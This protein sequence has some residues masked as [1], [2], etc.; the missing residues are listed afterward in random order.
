MLDFEHLK[1]RNAFDQVTLADGRNARL[2]G[3]YANV[4]ANSAP[5]R[6]DAPRLDQ[7]GD[8]IRQEIRHQSRTRT[9]VVPTTTGSDRPFHGL[10][11][12]D[13]TWVIAGPVS[14]RYLADHG[15]TVIKV[16]SEL[17]PDGLRR[18]GPLSDLEN[19]GWNSSHFYGDFNA[20]K[21]CIQLNLKH[22]S[23]LAVLKR[24]IAWA[25]VFVMNW[26]PGAA[27]R[28]GI[29]YESCREINPSLIML[30]TSLM[31]TDGPASSIGGYG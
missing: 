8:E 4:R 23:A 7:H 5:A 11:V 3:A 27:E 13:L 6:S 28:L 14:V 30:A 20:G 18:L 25:D 15:A 10:K 17:R 19:F 29:G 24:L 12:L 1:A 26:A 22:E 16:E 2:P 21:Q 9:K 31:G